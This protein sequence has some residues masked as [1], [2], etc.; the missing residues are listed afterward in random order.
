MNQVIDMNGEF[1]K[2][3]DEEKDLEQNFR[4]VDIESVD[5]FKSAIEDFDGLTIVD[6]YARWFTRSVKEVNKP[7]MIVRV[8]T[9][10]LKRTAEKYGVTDAASAFRGINE[11][12]ELT[13]RVI[14]GAQSRSD[15]K[16]FIQELS[17]NKRLRK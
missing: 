4:I 8:N 12:G 13:P 2:K 15:F 1:T 17:T 9:G 16:N 10:A 5:H 6:F 7:V 3:Q 11:K 14:Y